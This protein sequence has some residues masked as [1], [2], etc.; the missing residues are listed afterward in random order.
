[1]KEVIRAVWV[2]RSTRLPQDQQGN[3]RAPGNIAGAKLMGR[4]QVETAITG[5]LG[6][7][8]GTATHSEPLLI[9][10]INEEIPGC[11]VITHLFSERIPCGECK[12]RI[13]EQETRQTMSIIV[14]SFPIAWVPRETVTGQQAVA[15]RWRVIGFRRAGEM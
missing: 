4:M 7:S 11:P 10:R 15:R 8:V 9:G 12:N 1:M 5:E 3:E 6:G 2:V 13:T 14:C